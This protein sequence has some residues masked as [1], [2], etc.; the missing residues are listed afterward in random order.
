MSPGFTPSYTSFLFNLQTVK[1]PTSYKEAC[2][3]PEWVKAMEAELT[4]LEENKTWILTSLPEGKRPIGNKWVYN[5]KLN[6][7]GSVE[8][9]K[10]RLVAKGY[11]QEYGVDYDEVFSPVAKLVTVRLFIAIATSFQWHL[12]QLDVNNAFLHGFYM[13]TYT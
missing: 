2:S 5:V 12:H 7:D 8:R 6:S 10:A 13:M 1:E 11:S 4:A 9:C 3:Y